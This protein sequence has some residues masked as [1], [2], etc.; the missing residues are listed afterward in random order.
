MI[1]LGLPDFT[2]T[3]F[4]VVQ[5]FT[6]KSPYLNDQSVTLEIA[7]ENNYHVAYLFERFNTES[8]YDF[9]TLTDTV[10]DVQILS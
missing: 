4:D 6:T 1:S 5:N 8:G 10:N 7:C 3:D 9:L 2:V